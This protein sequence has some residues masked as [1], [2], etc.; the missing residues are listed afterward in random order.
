[1]VI[2][3]VKLLTVSIVQIRLKLAGFGENSE[4]RVSAIVLIYTVQ[5]NTRNTLLQPKII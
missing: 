1:M 3:D 5:T 4:W 2:F